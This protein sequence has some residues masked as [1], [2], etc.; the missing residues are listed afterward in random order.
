L[1]AVSGETKRE[2]RLLVARRLSAVELLDA[3]SACADATESGELYELLLSEERV[4]SER[5]S[6]E[7]AGAIVAGGLRV[8][9]ERLDKQTPDRALAALDTIAPIAKG[10]DAPALR[11][12][13]AHL[14]VVTLLQLDRLE[15]AEAVDG[16]GGPMTSAWLDGLRLAVNKPFAEEIADAI[17]KKFGSGLTEDQKAEVERIRQAAKS[18][19]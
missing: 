10:L 13:V 14:E 3:A 2:G 4:M 11:R 15:L 9:R 8:A 1:S 19:G 12:E 17:E 18:G 6:R 7:N 16:G 5:A